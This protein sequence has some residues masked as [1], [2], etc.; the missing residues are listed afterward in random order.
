MRSLPILPLLPLTLAIQPSAP[1]AVPANL[2]ELTWGKLNFLHTTCQRNDETDLCTD[3][4][5]EQ[6]TH[7]WHSGHLQ[8]PQ[9]SADWGD[10]Y[11][12]TMRMRELA[13][14]QGVDLLVVDTG[15]RIEGS[16][17]SDASDPKGKYVREI[18]SAVD[19][20][21]V[22]IGNHELYKEASSAN[23]YLFLR[24]HYA[25]H[26]VVSNVDIY[27]PL[28][29]ALVPMGA[30]FRKF[31]TK[32]T[33]TRITAFAFL[34]DF[35]LNANNTVVHPVANVVTE[36]WF[37]DA[38]LGD[39]TDLFLIIGHTPV[40]FSPEF[41]LILEA[42]RK[43]H[44][45]E[46]PV[47]FFGGHTHIRDFVVYD[48]LSTGLES[49]R[50]C[51]TVGWLSI[52]H[53][54]TA[55]AEDK[56]DN[57][58]PVL[59]S[60]T[61]IDFNRFSFAHHSRPRSLPFSYQPRSPS[62]LSP[63]HDHGHH[64][65]TRSGLHLSRTITSHRHTL[66]LDRIYSC[67]PSSYY[68]SR[69]P[70]TSPTS[71]YSLLQTRI[72]PDLVR[73][74]MRRGVP[75]VALINTGSIRFD[76]LKGRFGEDERWNVSPFTSNW[77]V[78]EGVPGEI[79]E[80]LASA[81]ERVGGPWVEEEGRGVL[82][83]VL[84]PQ[85]PLG[86]LEDYYEGLRRKHFGVQSKFKSKSK[87]KSNNH[88]NH[89]NYLHH[90]HFPQLPLKTPHQYHEIH[91][92][93]Q[94]LTPIPPPGY[95]THDDLYPCPPTANQ[96]CSPGDDTPHTPILS[97]PLPHAILANHSFPSHS[98][99]ASHTPVDVVFL[100]FIESYVLAALHAL[101]CTVPA[102]SKPYKIDLDDNKGAREDVTLTDII[103]EWVR[104]E[105]APG[106]DGNC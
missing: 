49:G 6:D 15:D 88:N 80:K 44:G 58:T 56:G 69:V 17:L 66:H 19:M 74:P 82:A 94:T 13:D 102:V 35:N 2:R 62:T 31:T 83:R 60:R 33:K 11:S 73:S 54:P 46:M 41:L 59:F 63:D 70:A 78:V 45:A 4:C 18:F 38:I 90:P 68:L 48:D 23:D 24:P 40:R 65:D 103:V 30:R 29:N 12:F 84:G 14:R 100:D 75:T 21:V 77:R 105:W 42:I 52:S 87:S 37:L 86:P 71:I 81:V 39:D 10:Y 96:P 7:G 47:Q 36:Q 85:I 34:F 50:Y 28:T 99:G 95:I 43:A 5:M 57:N 79:V 22:T 32:N 55:A 9:Y 20:D 92:R 16:G 91:S 1:P 51:E 64:F 27:S 3:G 26:Y 61:Y 72:L 25:D 98:P 97:Y 8:E 76:L 106:P 53:I 67:I 101:G 89:N 93:P 104:R